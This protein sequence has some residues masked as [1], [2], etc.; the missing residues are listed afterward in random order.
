[1]LRALA[2]ALGLSAVALVSP[3]LAQ[4]PVDDLRAVIA[5]AA[6]I[7]AEHER[8]RDELQDLGAQIVLAQET[9]EDIDAEIA[10]FAQDRDAIREAMIAAADAQKDASA[11]IAASE[12]ELASLRVEEGD[13]KRS[14]RARRGTLAEVLGAL[15]RMGRRPPPAI[16]VHPDDALG[17]VRSAILLGSVVPAI[18]T[19][20]EALGADLDRLASLRQDIEDQRVAFGDGLRRQR[21]EERRLARLFEEKERLEADRRLTLDALNARTAELAGQATSLEDLIGALEGDLA[22]ARSAEEEARRLAEIRAAETEA[23][24]LAAQEAESERRERVAVSEARTEPAAQ[25]DELRAGVGEADEPLEL[26]AL[27]PEEAPENR[28]Y[29]IASLRRDMAELDISAPFST[30]E[31]SLVHPVV[32]EVT[33]GF[34]EDDGFGRKSEGMVFASRAGDLVTAPADGRI[35]YSG[36]FRSYGQLLI[37]NAGDGYHIVLAGMREIDVDV[38]QF[39]LAG[40]PVAVMGSRRLASAGSRDLPPTE[41]SLYVEFRKDGKPVDPDPWWTDG[42]S[43]RTRNDS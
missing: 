8:A 37:L 36:P 32:G 7:E 3:A 34:G 14:L 9:I 29:D 1:M 27:P 16:L 25:P 30:L 12:A 21:E 39:V 41:P 26:A 13:V 43:G 24:R 6:E 31:G 42:A 2:A 35:L 18:R 10:A 33:R 15:E 17:S 4:A 5:R 22:A 19:E 28:S 38:G 20:T 23:R 11:Q 40:E